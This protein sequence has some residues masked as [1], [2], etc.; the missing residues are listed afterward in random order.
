MSCRRLICCR[1][2]DTA[3][4]NVSVGIEVDQSFA[5][6]ALLSHH[7][8]R[9]SSTIPGEHARRSRRWA[10]GFNST[11]AAAYRL[12]LSRRSFPVLACPWPACM[13][14]PSGAHVRFGLLALSNFPPQKIALTFVSSQFFSWAAAGRSSIDFGFVLFQMIS[15]RTQQ[16]QAIAGQRGH[17]ALCGM[18][19]ARPEGACRFQMVWVVDEPYARTA[20]HAP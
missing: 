14:R 7:D 13:G 18:A 12:R 8:P 10:H 19:I 20:Y 9:G 1:R 11:T 16:L 17:R 2:I 4:G 5:M 6:T 3:L 15:E